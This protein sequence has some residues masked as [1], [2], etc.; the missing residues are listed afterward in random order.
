MTENGNLPNTMS[1]FSVWS[2]VKTQFQNIKAS[3]VKYAK[4]ETL[5]RIYNLV[6]ERMSCGVS[7]VYPELC[8][9]EHLVKDEVRQTKID[10]Y[11]ESVGNTT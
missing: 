1:S 10:K 9:G 8:S 4:K 5:D 3:I 11:L 7:H 2:T 6:I